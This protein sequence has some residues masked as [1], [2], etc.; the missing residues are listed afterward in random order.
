VDMPFS[1][2]RKQCAAAWLHLVAA[3]MT[4]V[5]SCNDAEVASSRAL[6]SDHAPGTV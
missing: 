2:S 6:D 4:G 1:I 5:A 3:L